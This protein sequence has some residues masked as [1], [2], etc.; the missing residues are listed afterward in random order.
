[1]LL[2]VAWGRMH[3]SLFREF[4]RVPS[5]TSM[6]PP[7]HA[8]LYESDRTGTLWNISERTC[9][10]LP[11]AGGS[12]S[13][14]LWT[15]SPDRLPSVAWVRV[16]P[17]ALWSRTTSRWRVRIVCRWTHSPEGCKLLHG[18]RLS[19]RVGGRHSA[20]HSV[21]SLSLLS[22]YKKNST[23]YFISHSYY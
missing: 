11:T 16:C 23:L 8:C 20:R 22:L 10:A 18:S 12:G 6:A 9:R 19:V 3:G 14:D 5:P 7:C 21:Y 4:L 1:M 17:C 13:C 2:C 15:H